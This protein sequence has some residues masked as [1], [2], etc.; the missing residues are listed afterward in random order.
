MLAS[1]RLALV[2][3]VLELHRFQL[4]GDTMNVAARIESTGVPNSIHLSEDCA[5]LIIASGKPSWVD[6]RSRKISV[7]G[8][9][10][11]QSY[12][13]SAKDSGSGS[14][15]SRSSVEED[16]GVPETCENR[17][18]NDSGEESSPAARLERLVGWN[19]DQLLALLKN[20]VAHRGSS[21]SDEDIP[22]SIRKIGNEDASLLEEVKEIVELPD[23]NETAATNQQDPDDVEIP[24]PVVEEIRAYVA[25]VCDTYND[26][27]FHSFEMPV[28]SPYPFSSFCHVSLLLPT[29]SM[30]MGTHDHT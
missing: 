15:H 13:R 27:A 2:L 19:A 3:T 11:I 28:Q 7:K 4:F 26:N 24:P 14:N 1:F 23:Y 18:L 17:G 30:A 10:E 21:Y 22:A 20:V 6:K 8:K 25:A 5:N 29:W 12:W 9:G 16:E